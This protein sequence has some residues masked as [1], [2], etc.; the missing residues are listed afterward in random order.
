MKN[1]F[2]LL[3]VFIV[4]VI[5][6]SCRVGERGLGSEWKSQAQLKADL[7]KIT[8]AGYSKVCLFDLKSIHEYPD[9]RY[10]SL[11]KKYAQNGLQI[12]VYVQDVEPSQDTLDLVHSIGASSVIVYERDL[13]EL[14]RGAGVKTVWWSGTAYPPNHAAR[15]Q[16]MGWPDLRNEEV[17]EDIANWAVQ[18]PDV[19]GGLSLDYIRWNEVGDGR[20]AEQVTDLLRRIRINWDMNGNGPLSVAV[21]PYLGRY[22]DDGGALSVGQKWDEWLEDDLVDFVYPMAYNSKDIPAHLKEWETYGT[23]RVVPCLSV[24]DFD[25]R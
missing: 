1:R 23:D 19:D 17:R 5:V 24:I 16:Y 8:K 13:L 12:T 7:R 15:L 20:N 11:L 9:A 10:I 6:P 14:F 2:L 3:V 4:L 22:P 25:D 21:F 18:I